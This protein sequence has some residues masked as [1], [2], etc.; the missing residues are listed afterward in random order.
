MPLSVPT[1]NSISKNNVHKMMAIRTYA[2]QE[3][4]AE[5]LHGS[6]KHFHGNCSDFFSNPRFQLED[7]RWVSGLRFAFEVAAQEKVAHRQIW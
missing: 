7:S 6:L 3:A 4:N 5:I 1:K 2:F